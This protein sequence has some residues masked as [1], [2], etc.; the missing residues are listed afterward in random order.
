MD[1][2][3]FE[4]LETRW[5][6]NFYPC[7]IE[8]QGITYPSSEHAYQAAKTHSEFDKLAIAK[9]RTPGIAKRMGQKCKMRSDWDLVKRN[10]MKEIL[11]EKFNLEGLRQA[12]LETG[13]GYLEETNTWN[14]VYWG[15]CRG[16]GANNL[17]QV[18][19]EIREELRNV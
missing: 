14:D 19:M 4:K 2:Y 8:Y 6:S 3:G 9:T 7:T 18:L 1:I 17:G 16:V 15:V 5:L 11:R 13:D 12:L 10:I